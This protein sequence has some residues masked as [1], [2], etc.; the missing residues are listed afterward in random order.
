MQLGAATCYG[1]PAMYG[2]TIKLKAYIVGLMTLTAGAAV[3]TSCGGG[4]YGGSPTGPSG[5]GGSGGATTAS[6]TIRNG[7]AEPNEVRINVGDRVQF[8][9]EDGRPHQPT[10][11]P[12]LS[13]TDCPAANLPTL[14]AGQSGTTGSFGEV[15]ACGFHDHLNPDT[16]ALQGVIRV[17]NAEGPG[18]PVYI[19]H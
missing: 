19:K 3:L 9:N 17:G 11:N 18:G 6:I 2:A 1:G 13:H 15:K 14:A 16:T 5:G 4:G 12:H 8:V 10:S 7:R